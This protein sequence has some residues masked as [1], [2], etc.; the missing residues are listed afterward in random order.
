MI[1]Q[2]TRGLLSSGDQLALDLPFAETKSLAAR[3]GPTPTF[4]RASTATFVGSDG[5][6]QT[7]AVNAARFDHNP[8]TL[9]SRGLLIEEGRT[10]L[11]TQSETWQTGANFTGPTAPTVTNDTTTSPDGLLTADTLSGSTG[12]AIDGSANS[13]WRQPT[14]SSATAYTFSIYVRSLGVATKAEIRIR[15]NS[16]GASVQTLDTSLTSSWKRLSVTATTG[17]TTTSIRCI[18][19]N[20]DGPIAIW[21]AQ[22]EAGAF[23][24]SYI[25]TTTS[26]LARSADV[27]SITGSDFTGFY[28]Q[29]EGT[30]HSKSSQPVVTTANAMVYA[31]DSGSDNNRHNFSHSRSF[32]VTQRSGITS[33]LV[34]ANN[35]TSN[36]VSSFAAAY[37]ISNY[38]VGFNSVLLSSTS[39]EGPVPTVNRMFLGSK[40]IGTEYL[41]GHIASIRYYK[42]RLPD[43]KLQAITA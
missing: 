30:I 38:K 24:T 11:F 28:N 36:S 33:A 26:T 22:V 16:T 27:C 2:Q 29:T 10:N 23:A 8:I 32:F 15:D 31:I 42:I 18:I 21:G 20:T 3:I 34:D 40:G 5:L 1:L 25:P 43:A 13:T 4:T 17:A 7:A 41:N 6:I 12:T 14:I 39:G 9:A 35:P 19:Q 37:K